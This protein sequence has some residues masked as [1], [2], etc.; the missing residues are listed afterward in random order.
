MYFRAATISWLT[1]QQ[2]INLYHFWYYKNTELFWSQL[3]KCEYFA[4]PIENLWS[5]GLLARENKTFVDVTLDSGSNELITLQN[6]QQI[7]P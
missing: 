3:F 4:L 5:F 6:S 1:K 7:N 2:K